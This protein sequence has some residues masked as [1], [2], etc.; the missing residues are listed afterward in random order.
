M[1]GEEAL[2]SRWERLQREAQ[3]QSPPIQVVTVDPP[4]EEAPAVTPRTPQQTQPWVPGARSAAAPNLTAGRSPGEW[5]PDPGYRLLQGDPPR[6]VWTPGLPH[7]NRA[8]VEAAELEGR[9]R[10]APGYT[11]R[12]DIDGAAVWSPGAVHHLHPGQVA[13]E[14]EGTWIPAPE[15]T[16]RVAERTAP[17]APADETPGTQLDETWEP[18]AARLR[19][20]V[21][22][23]RWIDG[24]AADPE[25]RR[26]PRLGT[27]LELRDAEVAAAV[28]L[29]LPLEP[30]EERAA[31]QELILRGLESD[32]SGVA[33]DAA[34]LRVRLPKLRDADRAASLCTLLR[35]LA[36]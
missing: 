34:G 5:L 13:G 32:L 19:E 24:R 16:P 35:V 29:A 10:T 15:H 30:L 8:H 12:G 26:D 6:A 21:E 31:L 9:W 18:V 28:A 23:Q 36:R 3:T 22:W 4:A 25:G 7:P 11:F 1:R 33:M 17:V 27:A 14:E 2:E 20:A